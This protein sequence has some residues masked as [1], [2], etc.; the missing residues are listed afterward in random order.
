MSL[1][2]KD[3]AD[4]K[5]QEISIICHLLRTSVGNTPEQSQMFTS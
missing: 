5:F 1:S 4:K 3:L 2:N